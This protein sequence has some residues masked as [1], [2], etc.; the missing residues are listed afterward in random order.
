MRPDPQTPAAAWLDLVL[1]SACAGCGRPGAGVCRACRSGLPSAGEARPSPAPPGLGRCWASGEYE[2]VLAHAVVAHKERGRTSFA[3]FL[4]DRLALAVAAALDGCGAPG[5]ARVVL[6]PVPS[7]PGVVR[8]RGDDPLAR[9]VRVAAARLRREGRDVRVQAVLRSRRG[10]VDQAGLGVAARAA[11][12]AGSMTCPSPRLRRLARLGP[13]LVVLCDDVMT[14][15]ATLAEAGRALR[16]VGVRPQAS[17]VV[18]A[19]A[20]RS[21]GGAE[22]AKQGRRAPM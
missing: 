21:V 20:R 15:G 5:G 18:A 17:A 19:V 4:G 12:L 6:V 16:A 3:P 9:V 22:Q 10:V 8:A 1:G 2:G 14:T 7:R 11:N 13:V